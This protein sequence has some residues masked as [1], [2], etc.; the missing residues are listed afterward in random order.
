MQNKN[1]LL[2]KL[3]LIFIENDIYIFILFYMHGIYY[4][5][6]K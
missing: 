6:Y 3:Y 4:N 2:F 1:F 5:L